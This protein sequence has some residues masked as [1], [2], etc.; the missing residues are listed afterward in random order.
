AEPLG[1]SP[2]CR[3]VLFRP[4]GWRWLAL[5]RARRTTSKNLSQ[6]TSSRNWL[7]RRVHGRAVSRSYCWFAPLECGS[8]PSKAGSIAVSSGLRW[9]LVAVNDK[10]S[11]ARAAH[12]LAD[13]VGGVGD[14]KSTRLNSSHQIISYAVF[15]LKKKNTYINE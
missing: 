5:R 2:I 15:C 12:V 13:L 11:G 3:G 6:E 7:Y 9:T 8:A 14:R 10:C 4:V 1:R